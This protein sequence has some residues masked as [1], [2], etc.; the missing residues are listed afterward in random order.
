MNSSFSSLQTGLHL[1][2]VCNTGMTSCFRFNG[3]GPLLQCKEDNFRCP[4]AAILSMPL[5]FSMSQNPG[6]ALQGNLLDPL[7]RRKG[8]GVA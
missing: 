4:S 5:R 8:G 3:L 7:P 2:E 6:P 1:Q